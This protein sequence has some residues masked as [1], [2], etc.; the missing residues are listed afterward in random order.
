ML[1][2]HGPLK[3]FLSRSPAPKSTRAK[4]SKG[5]TTVTRKETDNLP[6]A[7]EDVSV[8]KQPVISTP[9]KA[10]GKPKPV[11]HSADLPEI[12]EAQAYFFVW[13]LEAD[14]FVS[15]YDEALDAKI[16]ERT[17]GN[18]NYWVAAT[19]D[20]G[21]LIMHK[22]AS[23]MNPRWSQQTHSLTWNYILGGTYGSW[24]FQFTSSEEYERFKIAFTKA[25]WET[26]HRVPWTQIK[27]S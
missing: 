8:A 23:D 17:S 7:I 2:E 12:A 22:I 4:A 1:L 26:L 9:K 21:D 25:A 24:A 3:V 20:E 19:C 15:A 14:G 11:P 10:V 5:K 13:D 6:A 27:V 18:Y 16:I